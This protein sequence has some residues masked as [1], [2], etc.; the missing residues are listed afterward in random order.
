LF[1]GAASP[2]RQ[3]LTRDTMARPGPDTSF[4]ILRGLYWLTVN[5]AASRSVLIAID[6]A[7][8]GDDPSLRWLAYLAKRL[9]GLEAALIVTLRPDEPRS[10]GRALLSVRAAADAT[11]RPALLSQQA[12]AVLARGTLGSATDGEICASIHRAT[13][14]NP[15]HLSVLSGRL[16]P[17]IRA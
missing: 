1:R 14:G 10:Q 9:D 12:V 15:D 2:A 6:D 4:A 3:L 17:E 11:V 13:G 8:W 7:H 5:L 16:T